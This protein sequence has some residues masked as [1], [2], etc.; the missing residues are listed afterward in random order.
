M[1][2]KKEG[3]KLVVTAKEFVPKS[4]DRKSVDQPDPAAASVA[5]PAAASGEGSGAKVGLNPS[6]KEFVPKIP[7]PELVGPVMYVVPAFIPIPGVEAVPPPA[8]P[9]GT[10]ERHL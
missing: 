5:A 6:A 10:S 7:G 8:L 9:E 4:K 2:E 3:F 1:T